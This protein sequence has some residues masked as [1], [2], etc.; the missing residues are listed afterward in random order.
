MA[1]EL[2]VGDLLKVRFRK[3]LFAQL[4]RES[5]GS[6]GVSQQ[7][8][9]VLDPRSRTSLARV[10]L[11][12]LIHVKRPMWSETRTLKEERRLWELATWREKAELY[13]LLGKGKVWEGEEDIED[14]PEIQSGSEPEGSSSTASS[15]DTDSGGRIH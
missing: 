8:L 4:G 10:M 7:G 1:N 12:E 6:L 11:H 15:S 5:G 13:R 9:I 3:L 14:E 2:T